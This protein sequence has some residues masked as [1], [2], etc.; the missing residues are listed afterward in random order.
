MY[1]KTNQHAPNHL[2][3]KLCATSQYFSEINQYFDGKK[4]EK[5]QL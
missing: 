4:K 2:A 5:K 3:E 1:S